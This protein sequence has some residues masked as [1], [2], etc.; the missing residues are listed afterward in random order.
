MC[1]IQLQQQDVDRTVPTNSC[2][3][4]QVGI[5][6]IA[7]NLWAGNYAIDVL[8]SDT[9]IVINVCTEYKGSMCRIHCIHIKKLQYY[10]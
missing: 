4:E 6:L 3:Y 8:S 9:G 10:I 2:M 5:V 7:M 1:S